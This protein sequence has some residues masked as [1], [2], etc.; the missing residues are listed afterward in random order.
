MNEHEWCY[1]EF[2]RCDGGGPG[3]Y[4]RYVENFQNEPTT[5]AAP[6]VRVLPVPEAPQGAEAVVGEG[7]GGVGGVRVPAGIT[8]TIGG[9]E[10]G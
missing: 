4:Y 5:D 1:A 10:G 6:V 8:G 9:A 3:E 2:Y 7:A